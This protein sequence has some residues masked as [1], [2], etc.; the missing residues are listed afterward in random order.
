MGVH[1]TRCDEF[2]QHPDGPEGYMAE[3]TSIIED[4]QSDGKARLPATRLLSN[5]LC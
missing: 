5:P 1:P 3:L 2:D 4:G